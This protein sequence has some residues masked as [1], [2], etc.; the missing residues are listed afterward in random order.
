MNELE[1]IVSLLSGDAPD[2]PDLIGDPATR[3]NGV[4]ITMVNPYA[5]RVAIQQPHYLDMLAACDFVWPDG[6]LLARAAARALGRDMPR[7]SFD[8]TSLAPVVFSAAG[9]ANASVFLVGSEAGIAER[10]AEQ[11][12]TEYGVRV[13]GTR[14]GFF[15]DDAQRLA[16]YEVLLAQTP[17]IVVCGM[18]LVHQERFLLGLRDAGWR[19]IG[20]TCGGYLHQTASSGARYYP[21]WVDRAHLRAPYRLFREPR[22]MARRYFVDYMPFFRQSAALALAGRGHL[23]SSQDGVSP[24]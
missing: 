23:R 8:N 16:F 21:E 9:A 6:I 18:G 13:V 15:D 2:W 22:R 5:V 17:S 4:V 12:L 3:P 11:F 24:P 7:R 14:H 19:G 10:A 20:I 1:R